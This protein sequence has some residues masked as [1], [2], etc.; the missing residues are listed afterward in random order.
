MQNLPSIPSGV[1]NEILG[2]NLWLELSEL[3][4]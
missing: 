3:E 1:Y 2:W 4:G